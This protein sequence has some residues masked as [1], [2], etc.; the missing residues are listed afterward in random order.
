[1][2]FSPAAHEGSSNGSSDERVGKVDL[3]AKIWTQPISRRCPRSYRT[4]Q[5]LARSSRHHLWS[6]GAGLPPAQAVSTGFHRATRSHSP[7][8][9]SCSRQGIVRVR[10][11]CASTRS[12]PSLVCHGCASQSLRMR[13]LESK[14]PVIR[15][16]ATCT[17]NATAW[18]GVGLNGMGLVSHNNR[19]HNN[20]LERTRSRSDG[21]TGPCRSTQCSAD[22]CRSDE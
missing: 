10:V 14:Y 19:T 5:L 1:M 11:V 6:S 22:L 12:P 9:C 2:T 7:V 15:P 20:G 21:L 17:S 13:L 8:G 18:S 4:G 16:S 3:S